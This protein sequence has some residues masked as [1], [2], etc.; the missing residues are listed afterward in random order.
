MPQD[1]ENTPPLQ[2]L[3]KYL[4]RQVPHFWRNKAHYIGYQEGYS[5]PASS[6]ALAA[7]QAQKSLHAP[8][9]SPLSATDTRNQEAV[10]EPSLTPVYATPATAKRLRNTQSI[11]GQNS[12]EGVRVTVLCGEDIGMEKNAL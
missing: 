11:Q 2:K 8:Q 9:Q 12:D 3:E 7:D 6:K 4:K 5:A 1:F 10:K